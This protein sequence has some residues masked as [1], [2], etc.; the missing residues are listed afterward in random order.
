[1]KKRKLK[2]ENI[3]CI[4]SFLFI[5]G[6][7]IFYGLRFVHYYKKFNPSKKESNGLLSVEIPKSSTLVTEGNGLYRLNGYYIYRGDVEDNYIMYSGLLFRILK[8]NY[9]SNIEI[10]LDSKI[11]MLAYDNGANYKDSDINRYLNEVFINKINKDGLEKMEVCIDVKKD[12]TNTKCKKTT[13]VYSTIIDGSTF[14]NTVNGTTYLNKEGSLLYLRDKIDGEIGN[15][16]ANGSQ[17]SYVNGNESYDIKPIISL[18]YDTKILSGTGT[19]DD[20]YIVDESNSKLGSTIKLGNYEWIIIDEDDNYSTL[21]LNGTLDTLKP[22]GNAFDL[23]D[24]N[25][26]AY[27]LNNEFLNNLDFK[28]DIVETEF[29]TGSYL[30]NYKSIESSKVKAKVGLLSIKDFKMDN[31]DNQYL[32]LNTNDADKVYAVDSNM[33]AVEKTMSKSVRPVVRVKNSKIAE[34]K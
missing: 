3:F 33:Y 14:I 28:D 19:K 30:N 6:C 9:G 24:V 29:E 17:I 22:F 13:K 11:N 18:K 16:I 5:L 23:N 31:L 20:P 2:K 1:M 27:Y 12:I 7:I 4:L 26:I 8:I 32:L 15:V 25:S 10:I 21:A 34:V